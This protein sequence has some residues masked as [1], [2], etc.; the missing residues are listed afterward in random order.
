MFCIFFCRRKQ[1]VIAF[2]RMGV[3]YSNIYSKD[4]TYWYVVKTLV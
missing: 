2:N 3:L 4:L 1:K